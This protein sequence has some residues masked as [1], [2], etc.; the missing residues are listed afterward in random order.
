[1]AH[2]PSVYIKDKEVNY[3]REIFAILGEGFRVGSFH[4]RP[5]C[6]GVWALWE[7]LDSPVIHGS[8]DALVGDYLR[9]LWINDVRQAAVPVLSRWCEAGKPGP[10]DTCELNESV[11]KWANDLPS[12]VT[13]ASCMFKVAEQLALCYTGYE[14]IPSSGDASGQYLFAG[15]SFGAICASGVEHAETMIWHTPMTLHGHVT[16]SR[17]NAAGAKGVGRP[18][19]PD[20]IK[21]Q[22][23]LA[24]EREARGELHEWQEKQPLAFPLSAEQCK[25][26]NL[27]ARFESLCEKA[28]GK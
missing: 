1:M 7:I 24:N 18:K 8:D 27:V 14:T 21:L 16:A 11:I 20:D 4:F 2:V 26:P 10:N 3:E 25:H 23:K 12:E 17:A 13:D 19:D 5:P 9:M 22:L 6:L 15:E 28:K